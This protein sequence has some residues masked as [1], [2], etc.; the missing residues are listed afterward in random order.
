MVG[1]G[2]TLMI[3]S[4]LMFKTVAEIFENANTLSYC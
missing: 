2:L 1:G 4:K 3:M